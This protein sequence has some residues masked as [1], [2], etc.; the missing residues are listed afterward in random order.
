MKLNTV[1]LRLFSVLGRTTLCLLL[2]LLLL[3]LSR[4]QYQ[5]H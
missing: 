1:L 5:T 4:R 2:P 3:P